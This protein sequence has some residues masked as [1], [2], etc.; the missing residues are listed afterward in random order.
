[1]K[2][3]LIEA[4]YLLENNKIEIH[5]KGRGQ[6]LEEL[7]GHSTRLWPSF[8]IF[9]I[10]YRDLRSRGFVVKPDL[11]EGFNVYDRGVN[12]KR[13]PS[14][15]RIL[16]LSERVPF[17]MEDII[18]KVI[19]AGGL[20]KS[21]IAAIV[22]EE[23]DLT[24]YKL[25]IVSPKGK[26]KRRKIRTTGTAVFMEDRIMVW[27]KNLVQ[28]L[29][30]FEFYGK[31]IGESLQLSL[32]EGAYLLGLGIIGLRNVKTNRRISPKGFLRKAK[33][34]QPDFELSSM[35]YTRLKEQGLIVKTGFKYG[36]H[37]RVYRGDPDIEHSDYLVHAV[38][39]EFSS[40]W[41]EISRAVRLA[42]GVRKD[43]LFGRIIDD[44]LQNLKIE[45]IRL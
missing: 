19:Q 41:P 12:P 24:Y 13:S 38:P 11:P 33:Q 7:I 26:I 22:D 30:Q 14:S 31:L 45:R 1:M 8:E 28:Q 18:D 6:S 3:E 25:E 27:D 4:I 20:R 29:Y 35:V 34:I 42:H 44:E 10:V 39:N 36:T 43:M 23:G 16:S 40:T 5:K 17:V 2:L 21:L 32:M 15:F 37:F 9:Y